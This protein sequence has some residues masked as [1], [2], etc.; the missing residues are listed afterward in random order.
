MQSWKKLHFPESLG[1]HKDWSG[2]CNLSV[3]PRC[4][5]YELDLTFSIFKFLHLLLST[6]LFSFVS[7]IPRLPL[8]VLVC[9]VSLMFLPYFLVHLNAVKRWH[10]AMWCLAMESDVRSLLIFVLALSPSPPSSIARTERTRK[11]Q[12]HF[13]GSYRDQGG[14]RSTTWRSIWSCTTRSRSTTLHGRP[15]TLF[16]KI[17]KS[18]WR[19]ALRFYYMTSYLRVHAVQC[20]IVFPTLVFLS[21][22]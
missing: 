22:N 6:D 12:K 3:F 8:I 5:F 19:Y 4:L 15:S 18:L 11:P 2:S 14:N 9:T 16:H 20:V 21:L 13:P 7:S 17:S 10:T 1:A